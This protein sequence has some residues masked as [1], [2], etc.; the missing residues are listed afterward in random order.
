MSPSKKFQWGGEASPEL[1]DH[2]QAKLNILSEYIQEYLSIVCT[3]RQMKDFDITIVDGFAGGGIYKDGEHGSPLVI[4]GAVNK[5]KIDINRKRQLPID[6]KPE[7]FF[8]EKDSSHFQSLLGVLHDHPDSKYI[9][10]MHGDFNLKLDEIIYAV[11]K[12]NPRG[13]GGVIFFLDQKGYDS[14]TMET[15]NKIGTYLPKAEII[16]IFAISWLVDF[17]HDTDKLT[18]YAN[19]MRLDTLDVS[20][21]IQKK[22]QFEDTRNVIEAMFSKAIQNASVFPYFR[23]FFIEPYGSHRGY[24]LLHLAPNYRAHNAMTEVTW[25]KGNTMR[26]YGGA[27]TRVLEIAYKG[28]LKGISASV[29]GEEFTQMARNYHIEVLTI[30]LPEVIAKAG[31]LTVKELIELTCNDTAATPDMY[32]KALSELSNAN[33]I[34]VLGKSGGKKRSEKINLTDR[35]KVERQLR[36]FLSK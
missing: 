26:Y 20:G 6:I 34:D 12:K 11:R 4:I 17:I 8:I 23:P 24:W 13:G 5:A 28:M 19:K 9:R 33:E 32:G 2:S 15:I 29:F 18:N 14:V 16:L 35:V 1:E 10:P 3:K 36:I 7:Y 30:D 22:D 31:N 25:R 21:I 27:G